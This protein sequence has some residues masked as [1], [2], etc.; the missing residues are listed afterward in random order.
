MFV[1]SIINVD[2]MIKDAQP[3][4]L[5]SLYPN[6]EVVFFGEIEGVSIFLLKDLGGVNGIGSFA[7]V[8]SLLCV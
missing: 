3:E 4:V 7:V 6:V 1:V 8:P 2:E 5:F